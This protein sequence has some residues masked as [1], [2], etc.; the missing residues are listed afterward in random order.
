M[1]MCKMCKSWIWECA[2]CAKVEYENVQNVQKLNKRM[3]KIKRV[4]HFNA[5]TN[6]K[7]PLNVDLRGT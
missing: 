7:T 6:D 4:E 1:R 5:K 2:T 3:C